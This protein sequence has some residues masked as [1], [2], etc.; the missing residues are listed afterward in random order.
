MSRA[1]QY[2]EVGD[3]EVLYIA[4]VPDVAPREGRV[5]LRVEAAG[6]NP[7]DAK[8]RSGFIRSNATFPRRIGSD[9]AGT[10]TAVGEG[11]FYWDGTPI[12]VGDAVMGRAFGSIAERAVAR[13]AGLTRRPEGVPIEVA[14][15]INVAGLTAFSCLVSV[16]VGPEDT[17]LV[18]GASGAVGMLVCQLG[19]ARG[20]R[21]IGTTG[22]RNFDFLR[23]LGVLPVLYGQGLSERVSQ[24][25][26]QVGAVTAVV[27]C[28]GRESLDAGVALGVPVERMTAIAA[29]KALEELGVQ[30][31]DNEART[32]ENLA[33]LARELED[34]RLTVPVAQSFSL[35]EVVQAFEALAGSHAPGKIVVLP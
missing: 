31:V 33:V 9:V 11:A 21:V 28:H 22:L 23:S 5:A 29:Y 4:E 32:A 35:D 30:N 26:T 19:L 34:G 10:V 3:P 6:L 8:V 17:L 27:D 1:A 2:D 24:L 12:L 20:A 14:G 25:G 7:Y 18:G 15:S 13:A 16:P